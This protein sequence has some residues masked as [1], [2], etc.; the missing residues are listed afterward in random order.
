M[1]GVQHSKV[2]MLKQVYSDMEKLHHNCYEFSIFNKLQAAGAGC[3]VGK[4]M[5][6]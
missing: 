1:G 5:S 2:L 6:G 3:I 4:C